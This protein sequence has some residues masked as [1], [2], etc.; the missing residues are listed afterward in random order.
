MSES[1]R[2]MIEHEI[3]LKAVNFAS[4]KEKKHP[5]RHVE[6]IHQWPARRPRSASRVAVAA[7]LLRVPEGEADLQTRLH[8][9]A[10]LAPYKCSA[11]ALEK[12][13][14][15]IREEHVGRCAKVPDVL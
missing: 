12:A 7:A 4:G 9:L 6:L 13:S 5:R 2:R 11:T 14:K 15:L 1:D 8:L 10:D 3:P